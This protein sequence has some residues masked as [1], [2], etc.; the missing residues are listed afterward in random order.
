MNTVCREELIVEVAVVDVA[1]VLL[2]LAIAVG[3][4][5]RATRGCEVSRNGDAQSRAIGEGNLLLYK[6]LT[7]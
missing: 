6:T 7:E 1:L 3:F 2:A 4:L 5:D